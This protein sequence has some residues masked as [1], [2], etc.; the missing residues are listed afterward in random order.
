MKSYTK[1]LTFKK[2]ITILLKLFKKYFSIIGLILIIMYP[3]YVF[4]FLHY[5]MHNCF[6][7]PGDGMC[8]LGVIIPLIPIFALHAALE[9]LPEII[10]YFVAGILFLI[11]LYCLGYFLQ[12]GLKMKHSFKKYFLIIPIIIAI[13]VIFLYM[14]FTLTV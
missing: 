14:L 1:K 9:F 2:A 10:S 11:F 4:I 3:L 13:I 6:E 7:D 5:N 8:K 12:Y